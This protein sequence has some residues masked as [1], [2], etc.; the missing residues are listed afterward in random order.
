MP[1]VPQQGAILPVLF[2]PS[3]FTDLNT[4]NA[5]GMAVY[6]LNVVTTQW[7]ERGILF[8]FQ[9]WNGLDDTYQTAVANSTL[10]QF[11]LT[12]DVAIP[13]GTVLVV[14]VTET[15]TALYSYSGTTTYAS[16]GAGVCASL[17]TMNTNG[18][19]LVFAFA[20]T[21]S[22][23][24]TPAF[25]QPMF[26]VG[27]NYP[28][29]TTQGLCEGTPAP[30]GAQLTA[31]NF[32]DQYLASSTD[33]TW[34]F[35]YEVVYPFQQPINMSD[36][37]TVTGIKFQNTHPVYVKG[38]WS[39]LREQITQPW[40][41]IE[42][43]YASVSK[44][45]AYSFT[46]SDPFT[47]QQTADVGPFVL[48]PMTA[49][50][51]PV[52]FRPMYQDTSTN[53]SPVTTGLFTPSAAIAFVVTSPLEPLTTVYFTVDEYDAVNGGFGPRTAG[54]GSSA[55]IDVDPSFSWVT[56]SCTIHAGTVIYM[57]NLGGTGAIT[58]VDAH[59]TLADVGSVVY[60][61]I[62]GK[63]VTSLIALGTWVTPGVGAARSS[64]A[65]EFVFAA[66]SDQYAGDFPPLAPCLSINKNRFVGQ[67]IYGR[68][69]I[70]D[71][72]CLPGTVQAPIINSA[73]FTSLEW[74]DEVTLAQLPVFTG[75]ADFAW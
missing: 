22:G 3:V 58:V 21:V 54:L 50:L 64:L 59:N 71:N 4:L 33:P 72:R 74:T 25:G 6:T 75:M 9:M 65:G 53:D 20:P 55:F 1:A 66:L 46:S 31:P 18:S 61:R 49:Q 11:D 56:G 47:L 48:T 73:D 40:T 2:Q 43:N 24:W 8:R 44:W 39:N 67:V 7:I 30:T 12:V 35:A 38:S 41:V 36:C 62:S 28:V 27:F 29:D 34:T 32:P 10:A 57:G 14:S 37:I 15:A 26:A 23:G 17:L 51:V 63:A 19:C 69:K 60:N 16:G 70:F 52:Y 42:T 5:N 68:G 45:V 13:P